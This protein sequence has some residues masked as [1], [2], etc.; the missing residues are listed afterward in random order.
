MENAI[1]YCGDLHIDAG[2][3][4]LILNLLSSI[5]SVVPVVDPPEP[6]SPE[7]DPDVKSQDYIRNV[8]VLARQHSDE[9]EG[10][11]NPDELLRYSRYIAD[12]QDIM[13]QLEKILEEVKLSRDSA[14]RFA[15]GLAEMVEEHIRMTIPPGVYHENGEPKETILI[16]DEGIKLKVV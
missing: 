9:L 13:V 10:L 8:F 16:S 12:Y 2:T 6:N 5:R 7:Y 14:W 4:K 11:F 1:S 3:R 15:S